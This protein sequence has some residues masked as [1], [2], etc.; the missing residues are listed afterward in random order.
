MKGNGVDGSAIKLSIRIGIIT[1]R[2]EK[3]LLGMDV[4]ITR[5]TD[6]CQVERP[7]KS[8]SR[9]VQSRPIMRWVIQ[10][11]ELTAGRMLS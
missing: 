8:I 9:F 4:T 10:G 11:T 6:Q 7:E 2:T 1:K 5:S 3:W